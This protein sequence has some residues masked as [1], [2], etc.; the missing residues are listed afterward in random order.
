MTDSR[1]RRRS[2]SGKRVSKP[3][4]RVAPR[5]ATPT[6]QVGRRPSNPGFLLLLA[7][8]WIACGV[9]A[10]VKLHA[11]WRLVP[12]IVFIGIGLYFLRGAV[13]SANRRQQQ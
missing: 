6:P 5:S 1:A 4:D 3:N 2:P 12:V 10:L 9:V 11:A 13:T 7:L 8:I